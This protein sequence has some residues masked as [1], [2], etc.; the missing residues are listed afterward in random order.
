VAGENPLPLL[1]S[2][3]DQIRRLD[4]NRDDL[5]EDRDALIRKA[6][7]LGVSERQIA[8]AAG[9]SQTRIHQIVSSG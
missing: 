9:L 2:L 8:Q 7:G 5:A 6:A 4:A 3:R 1:R